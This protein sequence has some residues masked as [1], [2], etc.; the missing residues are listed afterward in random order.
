MVN[1]DVKDYG[2]NPAG[3]MKALENYLKARPAFEIPDDEMPV[4]EHEQRMVLVSKINRVV[5]VAY[6]NFGLDAVHYAALMVAPLSHL[7]TLTDVSDPALHMMRDGL[8]GALKGMRRL[9]KTF[10]VGPTKAT[11]NE[12]PVRV[13]RNARERLECLARDGGRCLITQVDNPEVCHIVPYSWTAD[14]GNRIAVERALAR[15]ADILFP[16]TAIHAPAMQE[17]YRANGSCDKSWNMLSL[18]PTLHS[19]WGKAYFGL[20]YRGRSPAMESK[21]AVTLR[22]RWLRTPKETSPQTL[23]DVEDVLH[24]FS[25]SLVAKMQHDPKERHTSANFFDSN[26]PLSSGHLFYV[27]IDE[28]D[29][30]K[31]ITVIKVQWALLQ[32]AAMSAAAG[33]VELQMLDDSSD[34]DDNAVDDPSVDTPSIAEWARNVPDFAHLYSEELGLPWSG[35]LPEDAPSGGGGSVVTSP[36]AKEMLSCTSSSTS[37]EYEY[38]AAV[39]TSGFRRQTPSR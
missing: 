32:V 30:D 20:E 21:V 39:A 11:K 23:I 3:N 31:F 35:N 13:S 12:T 16:S 27:C 26:V 29:V 9:L 28:A 34:G 5:R 17:L 18:S 24:N 10:L 7:R 33:I 38:T 4:E 14:E 2:N 22:F 8:K 1:Q 37:Y 15:P 6:P 25:S 19:W 36:A